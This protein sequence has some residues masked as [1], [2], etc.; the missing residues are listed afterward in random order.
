MNKPKESEGEEIMWA[1]DD[2]EVYQFAVRRKDEEGN[3][4]VGESTTVCDYYRERYDIK[5]KFPKMPLIRISD[6]E[7][8]P[9]EFL[10]QGKLHCA[11]INLS[12]IIV[13]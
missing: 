8:F 2:P 13:V 12:I 11:P 5:L 9:V 10:R 7:Y 6:K 1:A 3:E 4:V